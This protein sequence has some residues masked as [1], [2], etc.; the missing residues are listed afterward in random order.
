MTFLQNRGIV[1]YVSAADSQQERSVFYIGKKRGKEK[2]TF[3]Q[4]LQ[5]SSV[6]SKQLIKNTTD[7]KEKRRHILIYNFKVYLVM[8]FCV[9]VVTLFSKIFGADNSVPGVVVL[10]AVLVLRQADFGVRTSHGLLCIAGIFGIL[11]AG[12]RITNMLHPVPAFFVNVACIL[13]LMIFGCHNVI[14]SNQSTFVLGYLLLQGYD[15]SG[16][17]YVLRVISLLIGMG[18][19]MAVFYKNQKNRP[20][21][22]TFLDLFR[23]FDVRSARNW[24]YIK[25]TLIVSSA[26]LIVSLLGWPR[27]MWA[28]IAAMSAILPAMDDMRYRV[29]W[30]IIGNIAGVC[31]FLALYFLLPS[32]IYAYIGVIGGIGVGFSAK[33]GWQAV[34]NTFG[35][36]AIATSAYGLKSAVGLRVAQNVFGVVFALLFCLILHRLFARWERSAS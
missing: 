3:Y 18:I 20:Y 31:C 14:M 8:A 34:F 25:L 9:A 17:A 6:G 4:E 7:K 19:C 30:R 2:M 10:L 16:H 23:E 32:S 13:I 28:G 27:A 12:P 24:W 11:I 1:R 5:L 33:Y 35:A 29:R 22:R 26:L 21:R 36:L 15:V